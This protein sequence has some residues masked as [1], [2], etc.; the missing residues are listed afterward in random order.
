MSQK[1][2]Y[3]GPMPAVYVPAHDEYLDIERGGVVEFADGLAASLLEQYENWQPEDATT[4][5]AE[6]VAQEEVS[7]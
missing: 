2:R 4:P 6:P 7:Q 5:P 1:L 3:V